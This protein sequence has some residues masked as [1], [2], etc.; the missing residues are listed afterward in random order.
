MTASEMAVKEKELELPMKDMEIE[1]ETHMGLNEGGYKKPV[2]KDPYELAD[3][4]VSN[5]IAWSELSSWG[6]VHRVVKTCLKIVVL[7]CL[8]YMFICSL[9]FLSSAFRLLGGKAAGE[10][11]ASNEILQN[12]VAGL[13]IGVL[14]TVLVQSSS[15]STSIIVAMVASKILKVSTAIPI[16]MGAN[17]GTSVTNTFVSLAQMS[18]RDQFRRAFAGATI[19]DMFN[20]LSVLV[21]LPIEAA[22]GALYRLT[23]YLIKQM[24][25]Q[26]TTKS[27]K[28]EFLKKL[29]NPFTKLIIQL[30]K[31]VIT[32]I[33]KGD[34]AAASKS[35]IKYWC[36]KGKKKV[37]QMPLNSTLHGASGLELFNSTTINKTITVHRKPCTFL[38]HDTGLSDTGVGLIMLCVSLVILCGCLIAIVKILHSML[39]GRIAS[40]IRNTVNSDLPKPFGFFT[41]YIAILVGAIMTFLV[42]SS[43]IFTSTL[44]PLVGL[45]IVSL[46]RIFPMTLGSNVGTTGT[47]IL[48]AMASSSD[49]L[50]F[51]LQIALCHLFFN[52]A[53]I[54]LWYPIPAIRKIPLNMAKFLGN[55]TAK[56]R[57]FAP[58]Y[59]A[60]F[61]FLI[62]GS[63][64][65]L[66]V[67]GRIWLF[68]VCG[69]VATLV[70]FIITLNMLQKK[71]PN[72][73]P[74]LMRTWEWVP[75]YLR[76]LEPYDKLIVKFCTFIKTLR[77]GGGSDNG[78]SLH[79]KTGNF[80]TLDKDFTVSSIV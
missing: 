75:V 79:L 35:L 39:Q 30:D 5:E 11:F 59:I 10:A 67:A 46:E 2:E 61:F 40:V 18:D 52:I 72:H 65:A 16:I 47:S 44:T 50:H 8:L 38:L 3:D 60:F 33:A 80:S 24:N 7:T 15:T 49:S 19:H 68:I 74:E 9:S 4:L 76:S 54:L 57:W 48:A 51:S 53:G 1:G 64:F 36:D 56:Y 41:G 6:R 69:L 29:T 13:M 32:K 20:I 71:A 55:T 73:L 23:D 58:V 66:S 70:V 26:Q 34:R 12:P 21:F 31:G 63:I 25:V 27:A 62:P 42:Q 45:G 78:V 28:R 14:A 22:C 77:T 37:I 17:I 43:S